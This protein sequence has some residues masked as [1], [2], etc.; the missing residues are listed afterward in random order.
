MTSNGFCHYILPRNGLLD[1]LEI[2]ENDSVL[3]TNIVLSESRIAM[4]YKN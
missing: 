4:R 1:E 2:L 3:L